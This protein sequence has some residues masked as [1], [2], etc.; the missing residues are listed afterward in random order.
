MSTI[1][2]GYTYHRDALHAFYASRPGVENA[3][4]EQMLALPDSL[5]D[6]LDT[7]LLAAAQ[8]K[9]IND[10]VA[11]CASCQELGCCVTNLPGGASRCDRA[12]EDGW[13]STTRDGCWVA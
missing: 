13:D 10:H 6:K 3:D 11:Q 1:V 12:S 2:P 7:L 5:L 4:G 8:E 9:A